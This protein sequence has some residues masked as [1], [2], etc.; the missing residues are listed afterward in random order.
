MGEQVRVSPEF[1]DYLKRTQREIERLTG[2][3]VSIPEVTSIVKPYQPPVINIIT[4][5]RKRP[6]VA[7]LGG[8]MD[9]E[10]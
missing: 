9:F 4:K 7:N 3:K 1:A 6:R 5:P 8:L 2:V 10:G